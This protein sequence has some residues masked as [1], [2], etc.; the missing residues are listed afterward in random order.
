LSFADFGEIK[1]ELEGNGGCYFIATMSDALE[2]ATIFNSLLERA[3]ERI[4]KESNR[5]DKIAFAGS[6]WA[7]QKGQWPQDDIAMLNAFVV[8]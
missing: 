3:A 4:R 8:C 1:Q 5:L 7:H 2:T 6:I